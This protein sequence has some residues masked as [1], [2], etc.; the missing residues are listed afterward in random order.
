MTTNDQ[1]KPT[2][3]GHGLF[4]VLPVDTDPLPE[5]KWFVDDGS[6]HCIE[7]EGKFVYLYTQS[8]L[9][10]LW[11]YPLFSI[12]T[13]LRLLGLGLLLKLLDFDVPPSTLR[14]WIGEYPFL[15][16]TVQKFYR[17]NFLAYICSPAYQDYLLMLDRA[18]LHRKSRIRRRQM[19]TWY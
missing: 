10:S 13:L 18:D 17:R 12:W 15:W 7:V 9:R 1:T 11:I 3:R 14:E 19:N 2:H 5:G 4:D 16:G 6:L 8:A